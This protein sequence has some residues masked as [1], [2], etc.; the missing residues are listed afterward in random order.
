MLGPALLAALAA[1]ASA[2]KPATAGGKPSATRGRPAAVT[3]PPAGPMTKGTPPPLAEPP[4]G[5]STAFE[6]LGTTVTRASDGRHHYA[7][8]SPWNADESLVLLLDG[9]ILDGQTYRRVRTV[10]VPA[11]HRTWANSDPAVVYGVTANRWVKLDASTGATTTLASFPE[12]RRLSYGGGEGNTDNEDRLAVLVGDERAPFLVDARTGAKRCT[13]ESRGKVSDA[14]MSQDGRWA[15][16]NWDK[17]GIDAYDAATCAFARSLTARSSH[18]DA[19]VSSAGDQVVVQANDGRLVMTRIADGAPT[20][21]Y[22]DTALRIHVS[23]RNVR[24]PGWAYVSLYNETCDRT[25][26]GM[27]AFGR[28]FA[29]RLDG[30]QLVEIYAWDH[31]P[32]PAPYD[33]NPVA[34]PSPRGDRVWWKV[35]WDGTSRGVHS[36]VARSAAR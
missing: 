19:C 34:A 15:L 36:F 1:L 16:V 20:T 14:T 27:N 17:R 4:L 25:L 30:S 24:R 21:V 11:G 35:N 10:S 18:Y 2:G 32:C 13:I 5:G 31:Q 23:C 22:A 7:K 6:D 26:R 9:Q 29:V 33:D 12:H 28:I 3:F 8:D